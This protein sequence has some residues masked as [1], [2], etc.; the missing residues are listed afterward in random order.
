M[1][2]T[3]R[4][5]LASAVGFAVAL[6]IVGAL[7]YVVGVDEVV[8]AVTRVDPRILAAIFGMIAVW[9]ACW[10]GSL[11]L[12]TRTFGVPLSAA[13]SLLVY[14]HL[15]FLDNVIPF[16]SIG[17]DAFAGVAIAERAGTEYETG[18]ATAITVDTL[19]FLPAPAFGVLGAA[20]LLVTTSLGETVV[21]LLAASLGVLVG[22]A[23]VGYLAWVYRDALQGVAATVVAGVLGRVGR[24]VPRFSPP[25]RADVERRIGSL[26]GNVE[27]MA[28][29][30]ATLLSILALAT[31]GWGLLAATFYLAVV[32]VGASVP[33]S[34]VFLLV[35]LV[36]VAELFPVPGGTGGYES[37]FVALLVALAGISPATATAAVLVH[38]AATYWLPVVV[39]GA[40]T[41]IIYRHLLAGDG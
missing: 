17:A 41:P 7:L 38:R 20:Y 22:L 25:D 33:V 24:V 39:G 29:S 35:P 4:I 15:Q 13:D 12:T 9:I 34:L 23:T 16:S 2:S 1:T 40:T 10:S 26:V 21:N 36:S 6:A 27:Q 28:D 31:A 11:Y 14:S 32:A 37:L 18:L 5:V 3:R 19:N 30:P 8:R